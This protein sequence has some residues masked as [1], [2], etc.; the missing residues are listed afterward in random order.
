VRNLRE[1]IELARQKPGALNFASIGVGSAPHLAAELFKSVANV[2][3]THV[4]YRGSSAQAITALIAGD[5]GMFMVGTSTAVPHIQSGNVRALAVT[6][7]KRVDSLPDIPTF[8]EAGLPG[9]DVSL[10]FAVLVPSATPPA[11]V[12]RL[13]A[14]IVRAVADPDY[15]KALETRGFEA[16]SSSSDQLAAFLENDYVKFRNLIQKL[17]LQVD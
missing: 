13:N 7:A 16:Q 17:K 4:P 1:F 3:I 5:V 9:V 15:K 8:A 12:K 10:W 6:S 14:D 2:D 11:I